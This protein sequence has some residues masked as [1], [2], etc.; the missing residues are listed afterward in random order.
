MYVHFLVVCSL[1]I[2]TLCLICVYHIFFQILLRTLFDT[3]QSS[4][5]STKIHRQIMKSKIPGN[6]HIYTLRPKYLQSF[7]KFCAAF[8]EELRWQIKTQSLMYWLTA[9]VKKNNDPLVK[10]SI[11]PQLVPWGIISLWY[12]YCC[13]KGVS[14]PTGV[15]NKLGNCTGCRKSSKT[16]C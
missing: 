1:Y 13:L 4:F 10:M 15:I 5:K 11:P 9:G 14:C 12:H 2:Y 16:C 7:A 6:V 3:G 8:K